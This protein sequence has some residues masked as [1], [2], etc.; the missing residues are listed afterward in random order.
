MKY[1][2]ET[3]DIDIITEPWNDF[4]GLPNF[5]QNKYEIQ[6]ATLDGISCLFIKPLNELPTIPALK[7]Q[8]NIIKNNKTQIPCVVL[9]DYINARQR[10]TLIK[11]RIPFVVNGT[12]IY[13]PFMGIVLNEKFS[14]PNPVVEKL[15]PTTQTLLFHYI[16]MNKK[17][18]YINDTAKR[19]DISAM[20]VTRAVKQLSSLGLIS[21]RKDG[22][23][24]VIEGNEED[25]ALFE[26]A[27]PY[28]INPARK[29]IYVD[30]I[31]LP[32]GL[33][34][35]GLSALSEYTMLAEPN[36][37][38][39][40]YYGKISELHGTDTLVDNEQVEVEVW[41]YNPNVLSARPGMADLLSVIAS[42]KDIENPRIE[43]AIEQIWRDRIWLEG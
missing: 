29:K 37:P 14:C 25:E 26:T 24:I 3:L 16:Y 7:K 2:T 32:K 12:Q 13:L 31:N 36:T 19:L 11:E 18:L 40:A 39:Y 43:Q 17:E 27:K 22:V 33:P 42:F 4:N 38:T 41:Q 10:R 35:S 30:R 28:L 23:K 20:Q 9:Y 5:I 21:V 1:L 15:M 6:K 34:L 8:L